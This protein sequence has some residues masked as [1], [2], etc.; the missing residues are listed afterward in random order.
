LYKA[1]VGDQGGSIALKHLQKQLYRL[2]FDHL[3]MVSGVKKTPVPPEI[4][5]Q[6][7]VSSFISLLIWALDKN[8]SYSAEQMTSF[9]RLLVQ[10]TIEMML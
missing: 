7:L 10:P 2:V 9:Y 4:L 8:T 6:H 3:R 5:A 1:L